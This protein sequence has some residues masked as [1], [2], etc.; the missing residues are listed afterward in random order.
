MAGVDLAVD[1]DEHRL[2]GGH[3][4]DQREAQRIQRHALG[5][6]HVLRAVVGLATAVDHGADAVGIAEPENAE[7]RDHRHRGVATP[8]AAVHAGH[9]AEDV[10]LVDAQL[11]LDLQLVGEYV[12]QYFRVRLGVDVAQVVDE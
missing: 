2:A 8:A 1:A 3:V 6:D 9:G 7:T 10:L 5:G 12:E 11:A 4:R